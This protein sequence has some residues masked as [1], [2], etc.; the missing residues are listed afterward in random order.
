MN[1]KKTI[2]TGTLLYHSVH[3]LCRVDRVMNEREGGKDVLKCVLVPK[4]AS[5]M[6]VRYVMPV[7]DLENSGFHE[8]VS[9]KGANEILDYLKVGD[10][11]EHAEAIT[12]VL[13]SFPTDYSL[14]T[15]AKTIRALSK[16]GLEIKDQRKRQ[17]LERSAKGLV[18]ELSWT[19]QMPLKETVQKVCKSLGGR[20]KMN[21]VVLTA[22]ERAGED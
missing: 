10:V 15:F 20:A 22:L 8:P 19:L 3:G 18:G 2:S 13:T 17:M 14:R 16:N 5:K 11:S 4:I 9:V 21:A 12:D 1:K 6:K 7:A